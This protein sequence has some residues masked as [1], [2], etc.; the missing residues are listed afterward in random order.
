MH[1]ETTANTVALLCWQ[2]MTRQ[3]RARRQSTHF[4]R[5]TGDRLQ[6]ACILS[7]WPWVNPLTGTPAAD[8]QGFRKY[9]NVYV[10]QKSRHRAGLYVAYTGPA[11]VGTALQM[12]WAAM[13]QPPVS[14]YIACTVP[15]IC[16]PPICHLISPALRLQMACNV[17]APDVPVNIACTVP[18]PD[19]PVI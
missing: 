8:C 7:G 14:Q 18:T 2:A 15:A 4:L 12:R 6:M 10:V 11:E 1:L 9:S 13:R 16:Q 19:V 3:D 17:P 5:L